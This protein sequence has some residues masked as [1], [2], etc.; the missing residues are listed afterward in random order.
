LAAQSAKVFRSARLALLAPKKFNLNVNSITFT[1]DRSR[2]HYQGGMSS[3]WHWSAKCGAQFYAQLDAAWPVIG[4]LGTQ[5][6]T[7]WGT[8][9]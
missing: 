1:A 4:F 6:A 7:L 9:D 8:H 3:S 2:L 5:S